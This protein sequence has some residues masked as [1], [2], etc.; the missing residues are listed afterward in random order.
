MGMLSSQGF[1]FMLMPQVVGPSR[2]EDDRIVSQQLVARLSPTAKAA[3]TVVED[4]L[5]PQQLVSLYSSMDYFVATRL[6]S[7]IF[8]LLGSVPV[9]AIAYEPKTMG[10]FSDLGLDSFVVD[11]RKLTADDLEQAFDRLAK[12]PLDLFERARQRAVELAE[13][14]IEAICANVLP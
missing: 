12:A 6:H 3:T 10:I 14:N 11:I 8:A 7:S 1:R 4:E 5:E 13:Q 9:M 2:G